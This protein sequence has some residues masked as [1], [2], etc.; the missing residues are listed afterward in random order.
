MKYKIQYK[1][2]ILIVDK[3]Y[4]QVSKRINCII[5]SSALYSGDLKDNRIKLILQ[6]THG[7]LIIPATDV[8]T[9]CRTIEL[10]YRRAHDITQINESNLAQNIAISV[11]SRVVKLGLFPALNNHNYDSDYN[12]TTQLIKTIALCYFRIRIFHETKKI[13]EDIIGKNKRKTLTRLA[14]FQ[15][16]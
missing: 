12:H 14:I 11:F 4:F 2:S 7:G 5:C 6:K 13:N 8:I 3:I 9:I 16:V 1:I 15:N 10:L